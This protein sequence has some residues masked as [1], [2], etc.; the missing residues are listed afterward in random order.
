[1]KQAKAY[2]EQARFLDMRI[3][4]KL[5]QLDSLKS[6]LLKLPAASPLPSQFPN[7]PLEASLS[8]G[9]ARRAKGVLGRAGPAGVLP[10]LSGE[11]PQCAHWGGEVSPVSKILSLQADINRDIDS[12]V[13]LKAAIIRQ[14]SA[15]PD[16]AMRTVL[17]L[18][19]L[20]NMPWERISKQLSYSLHYVYKLHNRALRELGKQIEE[21]SG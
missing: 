9:G 13:D 18:R 21:E 20:S 3:N 7:L 12:L 1:M 4:A 8:E 14:I 2:L 5:A 10:P 17:E 19:Y 16:P 11:V 15:L 6:L